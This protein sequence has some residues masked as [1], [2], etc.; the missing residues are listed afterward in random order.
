[1][2]SEKS[3]EMMAL[4]AELAGLKELNRKHEEDPAAGDR[5]AYRSRQQR[6]EEIKHEMKTLAEEKK[7]AQGTS[8]SEVAGQAT[9]E[10]PGSA[11]NVAPS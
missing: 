11:H 1:M 7:A 2:G 5:E 10:E 6:L 3:D 8:P 4:L 9:E